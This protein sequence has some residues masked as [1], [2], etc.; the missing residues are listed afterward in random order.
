MN[1]DTL[2][3]GFQLIRTGT[4]TEYVRTLAFEPDGEPTAASLLQ[5]RAEADAGL[6]ERLILKR[7]ENQE[8]Q[9]FHL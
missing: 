2:E 6:R 1:S 9:T 4:H 3:E 8:L 7:T 5:A